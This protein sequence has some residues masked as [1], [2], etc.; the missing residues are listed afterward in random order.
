MEIITVSKSAII[1]RHIYGAIPRTQRKKI[2]TLHFASSR[3]KL[4]VR[5]FHCIALRA[6]RQVKSMLY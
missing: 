1:W 2:D 3:V 6:L 5:A 4:Y